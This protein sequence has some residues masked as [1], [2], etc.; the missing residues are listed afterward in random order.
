MTMSNM[1]IEAG[2]AWS[3]PIDEATIEYVGPTY[4]PSGEKWIWRWRHGAI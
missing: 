1:T 4:M 2:A 3:M